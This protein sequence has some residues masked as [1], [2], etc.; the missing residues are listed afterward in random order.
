MAPLGHHTYASFLTNSFL[1][2]LQGRVQWKNSYQKII[3]SKILEKTLK[4]TYACRDIQ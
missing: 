1:C 3:Q 2:C 4:T